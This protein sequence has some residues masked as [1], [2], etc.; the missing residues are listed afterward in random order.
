VAR[1]AVRSD[2]NHVLAAQFFNHVRWKPFATR[3]A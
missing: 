1:D 3:F 2:V